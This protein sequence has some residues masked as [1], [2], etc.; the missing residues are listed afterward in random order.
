[1]KASVLAAFLKFTAPLEGRVPWMYLDDASPRGLVT[2]GVGNLCSLSFA[3]TLP[4]TVDGR[5]ATRAEIEAAWRA[6]DAAQARKHQGG[7][8]HGDL[9]RLRL[10]DT[11]IDA[12]VMA[13]VRG[14]E[15]ELCKVFPA[16]SSWPADAQ[17]FACSWAWAVGPHGRYPKM[18]ALL[19]KGD[20]E[21]A[22]KEATINPQRGTIVLRNKRNLQLLR[23]A[24]IVQEQGLDFEVL[25][26]PEA[27]E[28]AA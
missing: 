26:W 15:A 16:F 3:L 13:K 19:N 12:M 24:A 17:L 2:C 4:W 1:M 6:V 23:N 5:R 18:I 28:R 27:L 25:H 20:F 10:S 7:G 11:D 21:G 14:N 9:T 22:R 8:N